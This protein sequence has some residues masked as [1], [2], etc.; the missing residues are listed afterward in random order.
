MKKWIA[1]IFEKGSLSRAFIAVVSVAGLLLPM[2]PTVAQTWP[3]R[4]IRLIVPYPAGGAA[5]LHA[6]ILQA[7]LSQILG[8]QVVIEN[9][10]GAGGIIAFESVAH[11]PGDGYTLL[12]GAGAMTVAPSLYAKLSFDVIKDFEPITTLVMLQNVLTV[13]AD[14]PLK[15]VPELIA[16]AKSHPGK[17]TFASS[18]VGATPHLTVELFK[19]MAGMNIV[20]V[21]YRGDT[22]AYLAL[23]SHQVDMFFSTLGGGV[24]YIRGGKVRALAVSSQQRSPILPGVPPLADYVPGFNIVSWFGL[25]APKGTPADIVNKLNSAVRTL[26]AKPEIQK[27]YLDLGSEPSTDTPAEFRELIRSNVKTFAAIA[28]AANIKPE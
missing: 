17:M 25:L 16:Y 19:Q 4:P 21:P 12:L 1:R 14:S 7:P 18:G 15:S 20:H 28:K 24:S 13:P 9:K 6:R 27:A 11:A 3:S 2:A 8:Q 26:L 23:M 22:P 5:D 10:S